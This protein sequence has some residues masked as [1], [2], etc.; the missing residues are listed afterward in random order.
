MASPSASPLV[1]KDG[2]RRARNPQQPALRDT[3]LVP[4]IVHP[5]YT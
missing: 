5:H 1:V 4:P 3:D 2:Q